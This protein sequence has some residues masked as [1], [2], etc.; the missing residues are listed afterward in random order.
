MKLPTTTQK[1]SEPK[2][3][4]DDEMPG[5]AR[6][7]PGQGDLEE[8]FARL[9]RGFDRMA[10]VPPMDAEVA[11][12]PAALE[13]DIPDANPGLRPGVSADLDILF[14]GDW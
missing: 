13:A 1:R 2:R 11:A 4:K 9:T 10:P 3:V 5:D 14:G 8:E 7:R 12:D 6:A